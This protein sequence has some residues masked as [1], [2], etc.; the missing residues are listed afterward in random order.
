M[1]FALDIIPL[2]DWLSLPQ[3]KPLIIAGPCGA[4]SEQQVLKT[5]HAIKEN[6]LVKIFRAGVWKPRTRPDSFAGAG[7]IALEW[8]K[9]VKQETGL[10]TTVEVATPDHVE[11]ALK[12]GIDVL[13][14]GAR[15]T[16]SPFAMQELAESLRG[17]DIPVM[18][19]NPINPE[20]DLWKGALERINRAGIK[21]LVA[22][23][24]GFFTFEKTFYRNQPNW[25][26]P[27]E[28]KIS[29]PQLPVIC[30]PSHICGSTEFIPEVAQKALDLDMSGLMIESHIYP[31]K[32]LSDAKQQL[33]PGELTHLLNSLVYRSSANRSAENNEL[34]ELRIM[35]DEIDSRLLQSVS[36]RLNIVDKIG[37][38]K[39]E[40]NVTIFQLDR[41]KEIIR[42]RTGL[43][44]SLGLKKDFIKSLLQL[45]H[46]E[47]IRIQTKVMNKKDE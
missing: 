23:H 25:Q 10:L 38:Y 43:G 1:S 24:R 22:I 18:V 26:L 44:E 34:K 13:W 21:K 47:S 40:N 16:V 33:T 6:S 36:E 19:K 45:V 37:R 20:L 28:L 30:D 17:I 15:T 4:E 9:K 42:T 35:I 27:I 31:A 3:G 39:K 41:W 32:A 2:H 11:K 8:L 29:C 46:K 7:D 14:I 5:A 12:A